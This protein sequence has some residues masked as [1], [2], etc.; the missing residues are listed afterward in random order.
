[1]ESPIQLFHLGFDCFSCNDSSNS[2]AKRINA[3]LRIPSTG[4]IDDEANIRPSRKAKSA[5]SPIIEDALDDSDED[6]HYCVPGDESSSD[7][8]S[9]SASSDSNNAVAPK[10]P[11]KSSREC[12]IDYSGKFRTL[13]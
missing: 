3:V 2:V 5:K 6:A 12:L 1:M 13:Y 8:D 4:G 9:G 11:V 7:E 10:L